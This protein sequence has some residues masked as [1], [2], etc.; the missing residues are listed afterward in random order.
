MSNLINQLKQ[1]V[2]SGVVLKSE[3]LHNEDGDPYY[4]TLPQGF[5]VATIYDFINF[6][7]Y[8]DGLA[9]LIHSEITPG[10]YWAKRT[11]PDFQLQNSFF[12]FLERGRVYVLEV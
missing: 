9:Y 5:K 8:R 3:L 2:A 6:D 1:N 10:I 7:E 4:D 11:K 12:F